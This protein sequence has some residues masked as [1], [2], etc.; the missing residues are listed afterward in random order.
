MD[1]VFFGFIN[2]VFFYLCLMYY[3]IFIYSLWIVQ[4]RL[5][6]VW[7]VARS[8]PKIVW[9]ALAPWHLPNLFKLFVTPDH[10][11]LLRTT[12][13][14]AFQPVSIKFVWVKTIQNQHKHIIG[15]VVAIVRIYH[16]IDPE[17]YEHLYPPPHVILMILRFFSQLYSQK[18][19]S[20]KSWIKRTHHLLLLY[21]YCSQ[22]L[23][24]F[25]LSFVENT[26]WAV[27]WS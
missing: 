11:K 14:S 24:L 7:L 12:K 27:Q 13:H 9:S 10:Q 18:S 2:Y 4:C 6:I 15:W 20:E 16:F 3:V 1:C 5:Q 26:W 23:I 19:Y 17:P 22:E 25:V 8:N 21:I